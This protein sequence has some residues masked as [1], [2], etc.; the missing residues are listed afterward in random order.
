M[1]TTIYTGP[2]RVE[3]QANWFDATGRRHRKKFPRLHDARRHEHRMA[4]SKFGDKLRHAA[5][6]AFHHTHRKGP[7]V[8][9]LIEAE[10]KRVLATIDATR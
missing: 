7:Q 2:G 10:F 5:E 1:P 8:R 9:R 4:V 3:H 6:L